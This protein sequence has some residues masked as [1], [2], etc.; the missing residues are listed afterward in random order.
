LKALEFI[1]DP[2]LLKMVAERGQRLWAQEAVQGVSTEYRIKALELVEEVELL[3]M[4]AMVAQDKEVIDAAIEKL[5]AELGVG[6]YDEY[7]SAFSGFWPQLSTEAED[8]TED[9]KQK[10]RAILREFRDPRDAGVHRGFTSGTEWHSFTRAEDLRSKQTVSLIESGDLRLVGPLLALIRIECKGALTSS[11]SSWSGYHY[12]VNALGN[13]CEVVGALGDQR[14]IGPLI[15]EWRKV[16]N[17]LV[18]AEYSARSITLNGVKRC[19]ASAALGILKR[20]PVSIFR[21]FI[22]ESEPTLWWA[23]GRVRTHE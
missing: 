7:I 8:L 5:S 4:V 19:L 15:G 22:P 2:A 12:D 16:G 10:I 9:E 3:V 6:I 21:S 14:A 11:S 20:H 23:G 18:G 1:N 17:A 13:A